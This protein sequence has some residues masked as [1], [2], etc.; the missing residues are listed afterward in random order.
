MIKVGPVILIAIIGGFCT[1][2]QAQYIETVPAFEA[3][4][5]THGEFNTVSELN[6]AVSNDTSPSAD[7]LGAHYAKA[8]QQQ[9]DDAALEKLYKEDDHTRSLQDQAEYK[10]LSEKYLGDSTM[11][12]NSD[13]LTADIN[14]QFQTDY[15]QYSPKPY[16][17]TDT[18]SGPTIGA[19]NYP[20]VSNYQLSH[21]YTY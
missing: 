15:H 6:N 8:V 20:S 11:K 1:R 7:D 2:A 16:V 5:A 12:K 14:K 17:P 4:P 9:E 3:V 21:G 13:D 18:Y 10:R 19:N